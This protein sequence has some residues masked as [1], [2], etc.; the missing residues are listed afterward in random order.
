MLR[1]ELGTHYQDTTTILIA[2]RVS[3]VMNLD[4]ILVI[5]EGKV[6]GLG[7]HEYL[8]QT[9]DVYKEIYDSQMGEGG[10]VA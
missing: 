4:Y 1:K 2:Q 7:N 10:E 9:C 3:S 6:I 5:E 8:L